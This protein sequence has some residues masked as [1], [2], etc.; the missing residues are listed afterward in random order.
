MQS[1]YHILSAFGRLI[2]HP[3]P[4]DGVFRCDF[5]KISIPEL[6]QVRLLV[7]PEIA[8]LAALAI[9]PEYAQCLK[10]A[11]QF[12]EF[13]TTFLLQNIEMKTAVHYILAEMCGN[14]FFESILRSSMRLIHRMIEVVSPQPYNLHPAGMHR[15][16]V[17]GVLAGES[18]TA[19][20]VTKKHSVK[21]G[22]I[23]IRME[24]A[25]RE[26][27]IRPILDVC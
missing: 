4:Q 6:Y 8:R 5:N 21:F 25:Y 2:F 14:L 11:L 9:T 20:S 26:K 24:K 10:E 12:E 22:E 1:L 18:E 19:H 15:P 3:R 27:I 23:L 17:E 7:E 16:I 13:P